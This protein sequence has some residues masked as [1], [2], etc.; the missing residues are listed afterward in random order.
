MRTR[1]EPRISHDGPWTG[2]GRLASRGLKSTTWRGGTSTCTSAAFDSHTGTLV[3]IET[4][5][6]SSHPHSPVTSGFSCLWEERG[7][8]WEPWRKSWS[9]EGAWLQYCDLLAWFPFHHEGESRLWWKFYKIHLQR[10]QVLEVAQNR[11]KIM[12]DYLLLQ[13]SGS[14]RKKQW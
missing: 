4:V 14:R 3:S 5:L 11:K 12:W 1:A 2:Q 7:V 8:P 10:T 13:V 6:P 9:A